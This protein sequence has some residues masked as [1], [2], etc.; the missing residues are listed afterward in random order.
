MSEQ[1][2]SNHLMTINSAEEIPTFSTE[3]EEAGFWATHEAGDGLFDAAAHNAE[4]AA[5]MAALPKRRRLSSA[6][7]NPT[8]LRL[9]TELE[10]RLRHLAE[11]K[12]TSYQTL[13]KEFVL[14]RV[15]EE[16]KRLNVI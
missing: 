6:K 7:S 12:G 1:S 8:S 5:L 13:L 15:Y 2:K 11:L 14:E 4:A 10:R 9:G 16:E 3:A